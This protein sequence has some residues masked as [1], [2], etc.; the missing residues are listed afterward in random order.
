MFSNLDRIVTID[1]TYTNST[2]TIVHL[3]NWRHNHNKFQPVI[4]TLRKHLFI[5]TRVL[6]ESE[7][8]TFIVDNFRLLSP[9]KATGVDKISARMIKIAGPIIAPSLCKLMNCSLQSAVFPKRW[10]TAKVTP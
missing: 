9:N 5:S 3:P 4:L 8:V 2:T 7:A 1:C 6:A 10:Q